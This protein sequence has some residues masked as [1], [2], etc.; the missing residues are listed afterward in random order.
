MTFFWQNPTRTTKGDWMWRP[1]GERVFVPSVQITQ[2]KPEYNYEPV[3]GYSGLLIV[4]DI[5]DKV[6]GWIDTRTLGY[7]NAKAWMEG[8]KW[9]DWS[10]REGAR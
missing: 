1:N 9:I 6:I 7:E 3:R 8:T 4:W 10:K 2:D 5:N